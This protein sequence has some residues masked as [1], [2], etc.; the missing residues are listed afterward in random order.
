[1]EL[2]K[3]DIEELVNIINRALEE[4]KELSVN[5]WCDKVGVNKSTLKSKLSRG[6]Y[7]Y[8]SKLRSYSK[9]NITCNITSVEPVIKQDI[10]EFNNSIAID[11]VDIDKLNI[12]LNNLDDILKLISNKDITSNITIE[13]KETTVK[14]LRVNTELYNKIRDKAVKENKT[15]GSILNKALLDYLNK[16]GE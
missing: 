8:N 6:K 5:K 1:M 14:T 3:L 15:I 4:D 12:L 16:Y 13:N 10:E 7:I 11:K 2:L 9:K